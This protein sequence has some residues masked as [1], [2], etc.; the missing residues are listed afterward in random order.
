[1]R[2]RALLSRADVQAHTCKECEAVGVE[3]YF[4]SVARLNAHLRQHEAGL[5]FFLCVQCGE[6]MANRA[7]VIAQ[8]AIDAGCQFR[9]RQRA[10]GRRRARDSV[11]NEEVDENVC[12]RCQQIIPGSMH[13][14]DTHVQECEGEEMY[15]AELFLDGDAEDNVAD[16]GVTLEWT[17]L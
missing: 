8:H 13:R 9:E 5:M 10:V 2:A 1:M 6:R 15:S 14:L 16:N 11:E 4:F 3:K 7:D 12:P 17:C